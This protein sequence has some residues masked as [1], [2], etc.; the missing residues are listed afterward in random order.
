MSLTLVFNFVSF[1][2]LFSYLNC[3]HNCE[4]NIIIFEISSLIFFLSFFFSLK[5]ELSCQMSMGHHICKAK[6]GSRTNYFPFANPLVSPHPFSCFAYFFL[7]K[8]PY[9]I[10]SSHFLQGKPWSF[11]SGERNCACIMEEAVGELQIVS[12]RAAHFIS[13]MS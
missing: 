5:Y 2:E 9:V 4:I 7:Y 8:C 6:I 3:F 13:L 10:M 12:V 11:L 1:K